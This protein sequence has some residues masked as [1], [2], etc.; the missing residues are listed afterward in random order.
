MP[1][2]PP[3]QTARDP[4]PRALLA[5][6]APPRLLVVCKSNGEFHSAVNPNQI[7]QLI[8]QPDTFVWLDLQNPQEQS[9]A[10]LRQEFKFHALAIEDATRHHERPKLEAY[11]NYYFMVFYALS[12]DDTQRRL[13]GQALGLFIGS[14]YIVSVHQGEIHSIDE[15]IKR[16]QANAAEFGQ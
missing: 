1:I 6:P 7:D 16:W 10:L 2:D 8:N 12:Y 15:T 3:S 9:L 14:N 13:A 4:F 5:A 11:D